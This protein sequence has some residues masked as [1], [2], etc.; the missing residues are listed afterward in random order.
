MVSTGFGRLLNSEDSYAGLYAF[1]TG[2]AGVRP[3][4]LGSLK[5][6]EREA[7]EPLTFGGLGEET[8]HSDDFRPLSI[9][10]SSGIFIRKP[11]VLSTLAVFYDQVWLPYPYGFEKEGIWFR[12]DT[13]P[14]LQSHRQFRDDTYS[15][16]AEYWARFMIGHSPNPAASYSAR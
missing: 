1:L 12:R 9:T 2:Q 5:T 6:F 16:T 8:A 14:G 10:Y 11:E 7:V 13:F 4:E 3:G 15:W